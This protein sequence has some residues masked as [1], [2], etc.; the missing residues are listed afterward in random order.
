MGELLTQLTDTVYT[1]FRL[2]ESMGELLTQSTDTVYTAFRLLE[3]MGELLTHSKRIRGVH[4]QTLF[5]CL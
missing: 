3:S 5:V 4:I 1:A 2:L